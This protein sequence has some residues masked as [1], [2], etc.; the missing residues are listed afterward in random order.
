MNRFAMVIFV[1]LIALLGGCSEDS[2]LD[3]E[4]AELK[5]NPDIVSA[6]DF[7]LYKSADF[8]ATYHL[9]YEDDPMIKMTMKPMLAENG[10][11]QYELNYR[12]SAMTR[13]IHAYHASD[14]GYSINYGI[15]VGRG[16]QPDPIIPFPAQ[17]GE[18][19]LSFPASL[20]KEWTVEGD[21]WEVFYEITDMNATVQT[22]F[23]TF[24][25]AIVVESYDPDYDEQIQSYIVNGYGVVYEKFTYFDDT[26]QIIELADITFK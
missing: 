20:G 2:L 19:F 8:H 21:G 23:Q 6:E 18:L 3:S 24:T 13:R 1:L 17:E 9:Y 12:D 25:N 22:S 14:A 7:N 5:E 15:E 16:E 11:L 10:Y 4:N 26:T